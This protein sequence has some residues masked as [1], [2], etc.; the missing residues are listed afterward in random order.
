M[1]LNSNN[2]TKRSYSAVTNT[3]SSEP[4]RKRQR[5]SS[6]SAQPTRVQPAR[7]ARLQQSEREAAR[8]RAIR[9]LLRYQALPQEVSPKPQRETPSTRPSI[10]LHHIVHP[11]WKHLPFE[12]PGQIS[13][14]IAINA[15]ENESDIVSYAPQSAN[16]SHLPPWICD[17]VVCLQLPHRAAVVTRTE[18]DDLKTH[19]ML[20]GTDM[21]DALKHKER[22]QS[23]DFLGE[24]SSTVDWYFALTKTRGRNSEPTL[25]IRNPFDKSQH[26]FSIPTVMDLEAQR[27]RILLEMIKDD[28]KRKSSLSLAEVQDIFFKRTKILIVSCCPTGNSRTDKA[29]R[30]F[31]ENLHGK[32]IEQIQFPKQKVRFLNRA[33]ACARYHGSTH[34]RAQLAWACKTDKP[35]QTF[36][37]NFH[38]TAIVVLDVDACFT[39]VCTTLVQA[40]DGRC[41]VKASNK[42]VN[43][44]QGRIGLK[45]A[46]RDML[47]R[48][49]GQAISA[50][51]FESNQAYDEVLR[52]LVDDFGMAL[53]FFELNRSEM[54]LLFREGIS[55][56]RSHGHNTAAARKIVLSRGSVEAVVREWL[57]PIVGLAREHLLGLERALA[58]SKRQD[59]RL[60]VLMTG[61]WTQSPCIVKVFAAA[62]RSEGL[63][64][65]TSIMVDTTMDNSTSATLGAL[66]SMTA[67]H[68]G[69]WEEEVTKP[70]SLQAT[71]G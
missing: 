30:D 32:W 8:Q 63:P 17:T 57:A 55:H 9:L 5:I 41:S 34:L 61:F 62:L 16:G 36:A 21:E 45:K 18:V 12:K 14:K 67:D 42:S 68:D 11:Q 19:L 33:E 64:H 49:H 46:V 40:Q 6:P 28:F 26:E 58:A 65:T 60:Q 23:L 29:T 4:P 70:V 56:T 25:L 13:L 2:D 31:E 51:A 27:V 7:R 53:D 48:T 37:T 54:A 71:T 20:F 22:Y 38:R 43:S 69:C 3:P 15:H 10:I 35:V 50:A 47:G 24:E 44:V 39:G 1:E 52:G 66:W 59:T